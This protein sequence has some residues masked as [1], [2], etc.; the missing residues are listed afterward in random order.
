MHL[1]IRT[2][3]TWAGELACISLRSSHPHHPHLLPSVVYSAFRGLSIISPF[4]SGAIHIGGNHLSP[5]DVESSG[6]VTS[7]IAAVYRCPLSTHIRPRHRE[8]R[9]PGPD[10]CSSFSTRVPGR[11]DDDKEA[12]DI[13]SRIPGYFLSH[14]EKMTTW[15]LKPFDISASLNQVEG[16]RGALRSMGWTDSASRSF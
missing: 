9:S 11:H 10:L 4:L 3:M 16:E 5:L 14:G 8:I 15:S 12:A 1:A 7:Y 2:G 13:P 6:L